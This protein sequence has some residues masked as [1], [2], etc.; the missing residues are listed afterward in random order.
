MVVNWNTNFSLVNSSLERYNDAHLYKFTN[1]L[2][3]VADLVKTQ[4]TPPSDTKL[5]L[6]EMYSATDLAAMEVKV[7]K[8][9]ANHYVNVM[10][11]DS[12]KDKVPHMVKYLKAHINHSGECATWLLQQFLNPLILKECLMESTEKYMR[13]VLVGLLYTAMLKIYDREKGSL[14]DYWTDVE[15]KVPQ[16][17]QTV[18]GTLGLLL[19]QQLPHL[20]SFNKN[21]KQFLLLLARFT[22]LG[23]EA[24]QFLNRANAMERMLNYFH[25]ECSPFYKAF[26]AEEPRNL[27]VNEQPDIGLPT[28]E[29]ALSDK[30]GRLAKLKMQLRLKRLVDDTPKFTYLLEALANL[31]RA[32][33]NTQGKPTRYQLD[34]TDIELTEPD[35]V[36]F[37]PIPD[38]IDS[39]LLEATKP[40]VLH[41]VCKAY[42]HFAVHD[43]SIAEKLFQT[44]SY[45]LTNQTKGGD[46]SH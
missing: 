32:K 33:K 7:F 22:T 14:C 46:M 24:R 18:L 26:L 31:A 40:R 43:D 1:T 11:R 25:N 20:K 42:M 39:I 9:A 6:A 19:L 17:R 27:I 4:V 30:K 38:F 15:N 5:P 29:G 35:T 8:F 41:T 28:P 36:L 23:P 45:G 10:Q 37:L 34:Q 12:S 2:A 13:C 21:H 16:P 3:S 44:V